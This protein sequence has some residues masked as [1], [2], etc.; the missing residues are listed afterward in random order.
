L[1]EADITAGIVEAVRHSRYLKRIVSPKAK[2]KL[3][4]VVVQYGLTHGCPVK[5]LSEIC[6]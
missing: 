4:A 6:K 3:V 1:S 2:N 5:G